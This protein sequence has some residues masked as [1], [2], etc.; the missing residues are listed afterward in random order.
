MGRAEGL[1]TLMALR[2]LNAATCPSC[3]SK[4]T[5]RGGYVKDMHGSAWK[6][7]DC[8]KEFIIKTLVLVPNSA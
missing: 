2:P 8:G 3:K 7:R 4:H 6:C 1:A 5:A